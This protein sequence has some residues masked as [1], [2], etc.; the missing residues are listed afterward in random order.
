MIKP[1]ETVHDISHARALL[2]GWLRRYK[3]QCSEVIKKTWPETAKSRSKAFRQVVNFMK[4]AI[5][6]AMI[7]DSIRTSQHSSRKEYIAFSLEAIELDVDTREINILL[8]VPVCV[9][10][11]DSKHPN[12]E[13]RI[14]KPFLLSEHLLCRVIQRSQCRSLSELAEFFMP[15][16]TLLYENQIFEKSISESVICL[17]GHGY[18]ATV[19]DQEAGALVFKTWVSSGSWTPKSEAKL[20][21][22]ANRLSQE[23][24]AVLMSESEF[25]NAALLNPEDYLRDAIYVGTYSIDE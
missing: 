22:L 16:I 20:S 10:V 12:D 3:L 14:A 13:P 24:K 5:G 18:Y 7:F 9:T 4:A 21:L 17:F 2:K 23:G 11:I 25:A 8:D 6:D 19:Y 1:T 15:L